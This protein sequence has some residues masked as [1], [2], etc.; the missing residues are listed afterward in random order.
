MNSEMLK[1]CCSRCGHKSDFHE[2]KFVGPHICQPITLMNFD[3]KFEPFNIRGHEYR[4]AC[5]WP[6]K[7]DEIQ[8]HQNK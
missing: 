6:R 2:G 4:W 7:V 3:G 5:E 8:N 1:F